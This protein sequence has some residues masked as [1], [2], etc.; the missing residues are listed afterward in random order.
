MAIIVALLHDV[1]DDTYVGYDEV[2]SMFGEEIAKMVQKVSEL[3]SLNQLLRRNRRHRWES[4][5]V[6]RPLLNS[7][8]LEVMYCTKLA[9]A[10]RTVFSPFQNP[11]LLVSPDLWAVDISCS[12]LSVS[13]DGE[14]VAAQEFDIT[15][16]DL[17][18]FTNTT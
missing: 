6:V 5:T 12:W 17:L 13:L 10:H 4:G 9:A 3:S 11:Y 14:S 18:R 8:C 7:C 16:Q 1:I 2:I 15:L